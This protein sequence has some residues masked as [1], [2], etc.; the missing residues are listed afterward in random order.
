VVQVVDSYGNLTLTI[1]L[2]SLFDSQSLCICHLGKFD[3]LFSL[4]SKIT[5]LAADAL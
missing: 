3:A 4:L 1:S 5:F 2:T